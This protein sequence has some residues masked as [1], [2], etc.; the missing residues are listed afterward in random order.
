MSKIDKTD[1]PKMVSL[2]RLNKRTKEDGTVYFTGNIMV[3]K[4]KDV[5]TFTD[6]FNNKKIGIVIFA[7][8]YKQVEADADYKIFESRAPATSA[9]TNDDLPF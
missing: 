2:G 8:D 5:T 6:K 9:E 7:N 4:L 3:E 1:K